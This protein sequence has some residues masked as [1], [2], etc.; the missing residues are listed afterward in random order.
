MDRA[1]RLVDDE[2]ALYPEQE[3]GDGPPSVSSSRDCRFAPVFAS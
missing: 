2:I 1:A 3:K